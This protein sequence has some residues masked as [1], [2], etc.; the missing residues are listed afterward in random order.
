MGAVREGDGDEKAC[1]DTYQFW[2]N[3]PE[4]FGTAAREFPEYG[5]MGIHIS[6]VWGDLGKSQ[7]FQEWPL[8]FAGSVLRGF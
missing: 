5:D 2:E 6:L 4:N 8:N 3:F 1:S 7:D